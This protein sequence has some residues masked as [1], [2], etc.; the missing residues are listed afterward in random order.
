MGTDARLAGGSAPE[1]TPSSDE[2]LDLESGA[3]A[4]MRKSVEPDALVKRL[5]RVIAAAK[6]TPPRDPNQG[7]ATFSTGILDALPA[8]V[9][10]IDS[11]GLI[12]AV[13]VAW[14]RGAGRN[15]LHAG[16]GVGENYLEI[17]D[18]VVDAQGGEASRA[19]AGIRAVLA[20]EA[21]G[22]TLEFSC[23]AAAQPRWFRMAATP[24]HS[25]GPAGAV[26]MQIDIT[27]IKRG[28]EQQRADSEAQY[29]LLLNSTAEGIVRMDV[30]G[31][32]TFCNST[33][34]RLLG[35]SDSGA[36]MGKSVHEC[37]HHT[38]PDGAAIP[39]ET[40]KIH[41]AI[42][43]GR[44]THVDDEVFFRTDGSHFPAEYWSYPI[45]QQSAILGTVVTFLDI[46][47]R[48]DLEG[49]F[50][51][52][53]KMEAVGRLAGGVAHDFN[54]A[55]QVI[56]TYGE[57]LDERLV[58]D[59]TAAAH[60]RQIVAAGQRAASLTRQLLAFS[61]KRPLRPTLLDLSTVI[62]DLEEMLR[63]MIG[64][65]I[66]LHMTCGAD[67][68]AVRADQSQIEQIVLNLAGNAADAMPHGGDLFITT[69]SIDIGAGQ[70]HPRVPCA[71]GAYVM[72]TVRDTGSGM[73]PAV[74]ERIFEPFF[75]TKDAGKGTGLGLSTAYDI[76]RQCN[77]HVIVHSKVGAGTSFEIYLPAAAGALPGIP[78]IPS[79]RPAGGTETILLV[80][81]EGAL[82]T[83]VGET[84][85]AHGYVVLEAHDAK[86][87][88]EIA[89]GRN[90]RID[91]LL[92]DVILPG[93][94]GREVA[95]RLLRSR[96]ALKVM[97]MSGYADEF[98][99]AHGVS[100]PVNVLLEKPFPIALLLQRVRETL[101]RKS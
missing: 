73:T 50:L 44:G 25:A 20:G 92:T 36:L 100:G 82:R 58:D 89:G 45:V 8:A 96:P 67:L 11:S 61:R 39:I 18:N 1:H 38:R 53:Q 99:V 94:T 24:L 57:L 42:R 65:K 55:L 101:D 19:R 28:L 40:C 68:A 63:R 72:M 5:R 97:Y 83:V 79:S 10:L 54:N 74:Q 6:S 16:S 35:Y 95:D 84:L 12:V 30:A 93:G 56:L 86:H 91:L 27:D 13:N 87:G 32:C 26:I 81:D 85:R 59:T 70:E 78:R 71:P 47:A 60:N 23:G 98:S 22:F 62:H 77:G 69:S 33:A 34:A 49:Q 7:S 37:H 46:S 75:T 64:E 41:Q 2:H 9:A 66:E 3:D 17:R 43:T 15:V 52:A 80:E 21:P 76:V 90:A 51:Q 88:I 48:R 29:V 14:R 4:F 31:L